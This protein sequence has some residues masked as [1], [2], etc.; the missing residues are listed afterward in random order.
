MKVEN[1]WTLTKSKHTRFQ[2]WG[3]DGLEGG[4]HLEPRKEHDKGK[5]TQLQH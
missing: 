4:L 5:S 1:K 3:D 2:H